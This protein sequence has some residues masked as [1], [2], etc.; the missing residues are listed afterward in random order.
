MHLTFYLAD[1]LLYIFIA[2]FECVVQERLLGYSLQLCA[3]VPELWLRAPLF[4][5]RLITRAVGPPCTQNLNP[6]K[7]AKADPIS[8]QATLDICI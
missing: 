4:L 6:H 2:L 8:C 5:A 7:S 3:G 1:D